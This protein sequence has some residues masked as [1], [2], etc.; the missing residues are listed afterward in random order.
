MSSSSSPSQAQQE[1]KEG[2]GLLSDQR[3]SFLV[4]R[5]EVGSCK[6]CMYAQHIVVG[7]SHA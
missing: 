2:D 4:T 7:H 5:D 6:V 1:W 3:R